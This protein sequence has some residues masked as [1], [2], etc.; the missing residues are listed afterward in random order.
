ME[1]QMNSFQEYF[2]LRLKSVKLEEE[3]KETESKLAA[4]NE[5]YRKQRE[6]YE[7]LEREFINNNDVDKYYPIDGTDAV[8]VIE[9]TDYNRYVRV[10]HVGF[11]RDKN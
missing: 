8:L 1:I 10:L 9:E 11:P 3:I 5:Q 7:K 4:L 2:Q 6:V